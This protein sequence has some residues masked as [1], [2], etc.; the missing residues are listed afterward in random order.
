MTDDTFVQLFWTILLPTSVCLALVVGGFAHYLSVSPEYRR[1]LRLQRAKRAWA[2][3][4]TEGIPDGRE[5]PTEGS[6]SRT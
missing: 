3:M 5:H 1:Y 6:D 4:I 2:A